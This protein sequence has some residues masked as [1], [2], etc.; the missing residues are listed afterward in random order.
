MTE[1]DLSEADRECIRR[2]IE[3]IKAGRIVDYRDSFAKYATEELEIDN[4]SPPDGLLL[5]ECFRCKQHLPLKCFNADKARK[6]GLCTYCKECK[7]EMHLTRSELPKSQFDP[8]HRKRLRSF[9]QAEKVALAEIEARTGMRTCMDCG[10]ARPLTVEYFYRSN[11]KE[12][13]RICRSCFYNRGKARIS[14]MRCSPESWVWNQFTS[15]KASAKFRGIEFGFETKEQWVSELQ[16]PTHC[17]L[18][19]TPLELGKGKN[20]PKAPSIDRIDNEIG[21][22]PGNV[23]IISQGANARKGDLSL[24]ELQTLV[25]NLAKAH[26][27]LQ[28]SRQL[29]LQLG[30]P[31]ENNH[32]DDNHECKCRNCFIVEKLHQRLK[33][34]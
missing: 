1:D 28:D 5:K 16:M 9:S 24:R 34:T 27:K 13:K 3:D 17:P 30:M 21:Y 15:S 18:L 8:L 33:T 4:D 23:W 2:G 26:K 19:G 11:T 7:R 25:S 6:D 20:N 12:F 31:R 29:K 32:A 14:K 10:E 22:V